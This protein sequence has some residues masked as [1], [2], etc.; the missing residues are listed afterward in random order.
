MCL[1]LGAKKLNY[2]LPINERNNYLIM[3]ASAFCETINLD[4]FISLKRYNIQI[5]RDMTN[6]QNNYKL[7]AITVQ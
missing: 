1:K 5:I 6:Y 2:L 4:A 7:H 3:F